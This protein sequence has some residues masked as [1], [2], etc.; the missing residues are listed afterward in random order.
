MFPQL[1]LI[2]L[3]AFSPPKVGIEGLRYVL[4]SCATVSSYP[5][6]LSPGTIPGRAV[7]TCGVRFKPG[8]WSAKP[9]WAGGSRTT[10][11]SGCAGQQCLC[12]GPGILRTLIPAPHFWPPLLTTESSSLLIV[13]S[14]IQPLIPSCFQTIQFI[15]ILVPSSHSWKT[16]IRHSG[17]HLPPFGM[18]STMLDS[19]GCSPCP[20][21]KTWAP[22]THL[23]RLRAQ[24]F[25][26]MS[27]LF[28]YDL[29]SLSSP[30]YPMCPSY[31]CKSSIQMNL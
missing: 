15:T 18:I 5:V 12:W 30:F 21:G 1:T 14:I 17:K 25:P 31:L 19:G 9:L 23:A 29:P 16:L 4:H 6:S 28:P 2:P 27:F 11:A 8:E 3:M 22:I 20:G 24:I 13:P 26:H 10:G 7:Y